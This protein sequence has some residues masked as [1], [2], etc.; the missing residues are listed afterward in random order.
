MLFLGNCWGLYRHL[1]IYLYIGLI[2]P[3]LH[4]SGTIPD[5]EITLKSL[6]NMV[7]ICR[8]DF[9]RNSFKIWSVPG[10][11]LSFNFAINLVTSSVVK[12]S[13]SRGSESVKS[14]VGTF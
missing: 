1:F 5:A 3:I 12:G 9:F 10:L 11:L 7:V 2:T 8:G 13:L 14:R 6:V 4:C